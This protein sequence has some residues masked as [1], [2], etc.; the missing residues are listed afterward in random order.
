MGECPPSEI[1]GSSRGTPTLRTGKTCYDQ[2]ARAVLISGEDASTAVAFIRCFS[3]TYRVGVTDNG[4]PCSGTYTEAKAACENLNITTDDTL[5]ADFSVTLGTVIDDWRLAS[6]VDEAGF[7]CGTGCGA[8]NGMTWL[9][10]MLVDA[11]TSSPTI[12]PTPGS[13]APTT[14]APTTSSPTLA[15]SVA[16]TKG[17]TASP[18]AAPTNAPPPP[19]LPTGFDLEFTAAFV[20]QAELASFNTSDF[21]EEFVGAVADE[22]AAL[23]TPVDS[24]Q[25]RIKS[26]GLAAAP[27]GRRLLQT[28]GGVVTVVSTLLARG[29]EQGEGYFDAFYD[30]LTQNASVSLPTLNQTYG[31]LDLS[32]T[33]INGNHMVATVRLWDQPMPP[34]A[35]DLAFRREFVTLLTAEVARVA[36]VPVEHVSVRSIS[37]APQGG[38]LAEVEVLFM[39]AAADAMA[40]KNALAADATATL[41]AIAQAYGRITAQGTIVRESD[42]SSI[43]QPDSDD[44][45]AT[46]ASSFT[47]MLFAALA[48][49]LLAQLNIRY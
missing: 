19:P 15:P 21:R 37:A 47:G 18:T 34:F 38:S 31:A 23:G 41:P 6:D 2:F 30:R 4:L 9:M 32:A 42:I 1:L 46:K 44:S 12:S 16:P 35:N 3:P 5:S 20:N 13:A 17:P 45:A 33:K 29:V 22:L 36:Q 11:P 28:G 10:E 48:T 40:R 25:I 24:E 43:R 14:R 39:G 26:L 7:A 27:S 8:D 49:G